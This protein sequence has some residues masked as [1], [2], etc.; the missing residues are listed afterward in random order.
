LATF[1]ARTIFTSNIQSP[2]FANLVIVSLIRLP[3]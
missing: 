3:V 2:I 1:S